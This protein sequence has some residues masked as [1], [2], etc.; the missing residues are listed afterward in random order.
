MES[1]RKR[2]ALRT[3]Q[4]R[5]GKKQEF[6]QERKSGSDNIFNWLKKIT[7]SDPKVAETGIGS[8]FSVHARVRRN[9][10]RADFLRQVA[11]GMMKNSPEPICACKKNATSNKTLN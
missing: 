7:L 5:A 3:I 4:G 1:I 8:L 2:A 9:R 6:R 11:P 10:L